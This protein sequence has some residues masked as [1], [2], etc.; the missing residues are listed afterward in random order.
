MAKVQF[1]INEAFERVYGLYTRFP[2]FFPGKELDRKSLPEFSNVGPEY[3]EPQ[4]EDGQWVQVSPQTGLV[5]WDTFEFTIPGQNKVIRLPVT[6]VAELRT[7]K[8]LVITP[9]AGRDNS[10]KELI[11]SGDWEVMFRGIL[12]NL[13]QDVYPSSLVKDIN[14]LYES[15]TDSRVNGGIMQAVPVTSRQ[16]NDLGIHNLVFTDLSFPPMPGAQNACAFE[17]NALSDKD[18]LLEINS[19]ND[20]AGA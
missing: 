3:L 15:L 16:L 1:N 10:V 18:I 20:V 17:L 7:K 6:T 9:L 4:A 8:N 11:S 12:I 5:L 2:A 13:E 14:L 19:L